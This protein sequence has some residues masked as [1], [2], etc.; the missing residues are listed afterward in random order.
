MGRTR[1]AIA[2]LIGLA[3]CSGQPHTDAELIAQAQRA[4]NRKL[5]IQGQFSLMES[6]I[7]QKIAC[8]HVGTPGTDGRD[9]VYR[10]GKLILDDDPDFDD[11]AV[12]CDAAVGGGGGQSAGE[13]L[14][15]G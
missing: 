8:G 14:A 4:V 5:A 1:I 3:G 10:D 13:N 6:A 7:A 11:A 15:D 12:Q 2:C 9:F